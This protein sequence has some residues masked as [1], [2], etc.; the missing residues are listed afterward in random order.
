MAADGVFVSSVY[1]ELYEDE[2]R[3]FIAELEGENA[4]ATSDDNDDDEEF[5]AL[6]GGY[7]LVALPSP[8]D[9]YDASPPSNGKPSWWQFWRRN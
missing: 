9:G 2:I 8:A 5:P 7:D 4:K 3:A 6:N 1:D